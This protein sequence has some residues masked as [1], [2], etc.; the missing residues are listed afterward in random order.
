MSK[1]AHKGNEDTK[2]RERNLKLSIDGKKAII[3]DVKIK[4]EEQ[5]QALFLT[6]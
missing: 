6:L 1:D 5:E 2:I 4:K 3:T